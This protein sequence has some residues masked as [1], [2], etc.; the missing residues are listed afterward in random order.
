MAV[1][2]GL[3]VDSEDES[4]TSHFLEH[5]LVGGSQKRI[6]LI[7]E[8]EKIGGISNFETSRE[9]TFSIVDVFPQNLLQ[10]SKILSELLFDDTFNKEKREHEHKII[11]NEISEAY[12]DPRNKT[13]EALIKCLFR[14][15]PIRNPILG[16]RKTVSQ[17]T[18]N[19]IQEAHEK[20]YY[21]KNMILALTGKFSERDAE[22]LLEDFQERERAIQ[23]QDQ[24]ATLQ[25]VNQKKVSYEEIRDNSGLLEFWSQNHSS[26]GCR[27]PCD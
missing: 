8:I 4:G 6:T 5:M 19:K 25:I 11:L 1:K 3:N 26:K 10:A 27:Y 24:N 9:C 18:L 20:Y 13:E 22:L 2:Y 23:Y 17:I 14:T 12:D 7:D 15:H 16:S 21:P